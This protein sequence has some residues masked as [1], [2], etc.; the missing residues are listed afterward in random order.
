MQKLFYVICRW[1]ETEESRQSERLSESIKHDME[2]VGFRY[3]DISNT[4][5]QREQLYR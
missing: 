4:E 1:L 5:R 3:D 2:I